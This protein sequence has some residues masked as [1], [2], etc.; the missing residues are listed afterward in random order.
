M[1]TT[2]IDALVVELGLD[3]RQFTEGQKKA[4]ESTIKFRK[5]IESE[6]KNIDSLVSK[7]RANV[8]AMF[9]AFTAGKGLVEFT[10]DTVE[11]DA[12]MGRYARTLDTTVGILSAWRGIA[13]LAGGTAAGMT[14]SIQN[15]VSQFQTFTLTGE[16]S[17]IPYFRA[18]GVNIADS[19]GHMRATGDI[20]LDLADRF[21]KLDPARAAAFG[22]ALGLDQT[23]I[24]LLLQGRGA[25]QAMLD[26]QKRLGIVTNQDAEAGIKLQHSWGALGQAST[27]LGRELLTDLAP[28]LIKILDGLTNFAIW[29]RQ[30]GPL[31]R[32]MFYGLAAGAVALGVA[33]L[34]PYAEIIALTAA[35]AAQIVVFSL[36]YDDWQTWMHGGKSLFG[37]FFSSVA[38]GFKDFVKTFQD[39][40]SIIHDLF[41]GN[42]S[43]A[44]SDGK[45]FFKDQFEVAKDAGGAGMGAWHGI[46]R[47]VSSGVA[48]VWKA[49]GNSGGGSSS[50]AWAAA[51]AA[52]AKTGIPAS[53]TYAQWALESGYGKHTPAGSNNPFGIKARHGQPY[54]EALTTEVIGGKSQQVMA[55]FAKYASLGAA[56]AAHANLLATAPAYANAR[57][58]EGDPYAFANALT[59]TYATDP[60]YG[61]K[62]AAI[63]SGGGG[64]S[65]TS[66][67]KIGTLNVYSANTN[68]A[69]IAQD[70]KSALEKNSFA[71]Q[72]N[73][74]AR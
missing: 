44:L 23:T 65:S 70:I 39:G 52:E 15:L 64:K 16:S 46:S 9:A 17:V 1:G 36:L 21:Q 49:T 59:G 66:S 32:A 6:G 24:N 51:K 8:L 12:S 57:R 67:T 47:L 40:F 74:G 56:F 30:H 54:V 35:V 37:D 33:L 11:A 19:N 53:V 2:V 34:A 20:L 14:G 3:P 27:S 68:A 41:T 73:Y 18:L 43:K 25:I 10:K 50:D 58:N 63:M 45:T 71:T 7:L 72:A 62:L 69:G 31:V 13:V 5:G 4:A 22:Q 61:A 48:A 60:L 55:R 28:S 42:L 38:K 29:A 26:E